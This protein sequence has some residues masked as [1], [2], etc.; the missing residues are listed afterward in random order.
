M[1]E[2]SSSQLSSGS[3]SPIEIASRYKRADLNSAI[4]MSAQLRVA[5]QHRID[6]TQAELLPLSGQ[7]RAIRLRDNKNGAAS[8]AQRGLPS[9]SIQCIWSRAS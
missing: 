3:R 5:E 6:M 1:A 4:A 9:G 2:T 8:T 7:R